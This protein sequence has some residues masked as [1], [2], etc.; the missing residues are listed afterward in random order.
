MSLPMRLWGPF[1]IHTTTVL[2]SS[3]LEQRLHTADEQGGQEQAK[4][5]I[6]ERHSTHQIMIAENTEAFWEN[7]VW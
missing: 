3:A 2:L 4:E 1:F 7:V 6:N 5:Q